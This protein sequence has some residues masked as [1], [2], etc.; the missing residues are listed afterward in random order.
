GMDDADIRN[1]FRSWGPGKY[2]AEFNQDG[3]VSRPD[4]RSAATVLP[5]AFGLAGVNLHTYTGW[6][7]VTYWNA[8][9]ANTQMHGKGVFF[10]PRM[11]DPQRF[12]LAVKSGDWNKRE[13]PDLITA[14]LA[15]LHYYQL[16]IPAPD[17]PKGSFDAAAAS[18]GKALFEGKARCGT[19][20]VPP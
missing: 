20:H 5:A 10:D 17:P 6:G 9:V 19:C 11:N 18:R 13:T 16:S 8:Y 4:G 12:P 3:K 2:D 1:V 14:K 7:S 15:A